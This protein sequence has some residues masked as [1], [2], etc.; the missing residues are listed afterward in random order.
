MTS[1]ADHPT[2]TLRIALAQLNTSVGDIAGNCDKIVEWTGRA[3]A[4]GADVVAFPEMAVVG[5]QVDDLALRYSFIEAS[6]A[7]LDGLA[8]RLAEAGHGDV[9]VVV[10]YLD[11]S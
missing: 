3:A 2:S 6:R 10:G 8:G 1:S 9:V 4:L 5:Y 7:A 11:V